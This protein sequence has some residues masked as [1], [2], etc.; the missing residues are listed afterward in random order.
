MS[1]KQGRFTADEV[2]RVL[3]VIGFEKIIQNGSHQSGIIKSNKVYC[4]F[5]KT[6]LV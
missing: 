3:S 2:I 5:L 1:A 6:I 4:Y